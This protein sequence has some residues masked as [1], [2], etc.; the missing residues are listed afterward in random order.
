[1]K[2]PFEVPEKKQIR[3][4]INS[5]A[6]C[7]ADDQYAIVHAIL[8]PRL[9]I[10]GLIGAH[11]G[12]RSATGA[13]DSYQEILHVLDLMG[14]SEKYK[15]V[16]GANHKIPNILTPVPSEGANLIIKEAMKDDS[17]PLFVTFQGPLTDLASA[18]L[19]EP[20]IAN[21]LT[22]V[23]IGGGTYPNGDTEFNLSNDIEAA[24]VVFDSPIPLWQVPKNVYDMV[25]VGLAEL[26]VKVRPHG[27]IGRYLYEYLI[28]HNI[29]NGNR[30]QWPK[31]E[32]W[33]LG[34]SP[35]VSLLLDDQVFDYDLIEAPE[36]TSEMGYRH[37]PGNRKIRVYRSVDSRFILE[38]F[39][40]KLELFINFNQGEVMQ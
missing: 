35:A 4:I 13:E 20:R 25:R 21:R 9:Q 31:G 1:M 32:I 15:V 30:P 26:A 14:L 23:W 22:A 40:A 17:L 19:Q 3:V 2:M 27:E 12:T 28:Q 10:K 7:E 18:Y 24:K 16:K 36:I 8:S 5:D 38:D 6:K 29:K 33:V 37:K 39:Y 34:D 11:F